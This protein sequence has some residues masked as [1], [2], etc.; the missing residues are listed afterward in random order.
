M[1]SFVQEEQGGEDYLRRG[2]RG[3][4][5][6]GKLFPAGGA[7]AVVRRGKTER[8]PLKD[9]G[10]T[11]RKSRGLAVFLRKTGPTLPGNK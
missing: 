7:S 8:M 9:V 2:L 11:R 3:K 5:R 10:A 1:G 6:M 4:G